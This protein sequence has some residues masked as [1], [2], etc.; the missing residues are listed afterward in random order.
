MCEY[1]LVSNLKSRDI[2][3][4]ICKDLNHPEIIKSTSVLFAWDES[5]LEKWQK[6]EYDAM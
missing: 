5:G 4:T 1:F 2:F 3:R 6:V